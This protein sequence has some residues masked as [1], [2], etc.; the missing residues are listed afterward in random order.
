MNEIIKI[1]RINSRKEL[2]NLRKHNSLGVNRSV[3]YIYYLTNRYITY[4]KS[5]GCILYIGEALREIKPT[6]ERFG[7]HI[8]T[9]KF[10]GADTNNNLILS[11]YFYEKWSIGLK[12]YE[13]S[14]RNKMERDLIYS[15]IDEYGAPPIA[16]GKIPN[17][18]DGR[19]QV[20]HIYSYIKNNTESINNLKML[21]KQIK[22]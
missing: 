3:V 8:S 5:S 16:Q 13:T 12:I 21:L 17:D 18:D 20:S 14:D 22:I 9:S 2:L 4:P 11:Q 7:K 15:H 1:K 19:N 10:I 6:G